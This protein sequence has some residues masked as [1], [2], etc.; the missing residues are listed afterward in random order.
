MRPLSHL[1]PC[2]PTRASRAR[3]QKKPLKWAKP[4]A[5]PTTK[6]VP[7]SFAFTIPAGIRAPVTLSLPVDKV[8]SAWLAPGGAQ[9]FGLMIKL[10]AKQAGSVLL[11]SAGYNNLIN[12]PSLKLTYRLAEV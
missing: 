6:V 9:N 3:R 2:G 7:N 10:Q 8:Q 12:R 5:F 11:V 4:G 1:P